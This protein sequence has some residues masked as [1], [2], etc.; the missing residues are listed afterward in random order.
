MLRV[1]LNKGKYGEYL[2]SR[3]IEKS[4][5][6]SHK[7]L[8]NVYLPKKNSDELIELDLIYIDQTGLYVIE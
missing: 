1:M 2:T 8:V 4:A 7:Q 3:I 5:L 6:K